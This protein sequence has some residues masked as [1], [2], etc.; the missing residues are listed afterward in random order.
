VLGALGGSITH[1]FA[2]FNTLVKY[3][4]HPRIRLSLLSDDCFATVAPPGR[5]VFRLARHGARV[6]CG[7]I[8]IGEPAHDVTTSGFRWNLC[9]STG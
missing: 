1:E 4:G 8:P 3:C 9:E 6:P 2:S 7:I 5:S